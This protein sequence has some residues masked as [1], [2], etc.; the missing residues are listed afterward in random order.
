[1]ARSEVLR[2][3]V[4]GAARIAPAAIIRPA[5]AVDGV[6]VVA[7]AAR[8][9]DRARSFAARHGIGKVHESY[10]SLLADDDVDAVYN[11][12]PNG[13]HG[14]WTIA[15][16]E[17]GKHVLCEKPFTANA[18]EAEDVAAVARRTDRTVMEA[19][20]YRYHPLA[21]RLVSLVR[22]GELGELRRIE[23]WF[24]SPLVRGSD[25]R[26]QRALAGGSTMDLGC[27]TIHLVRAL[28]GSEPEVV[29][30]SARE[31]GAGVDRW[32]DAEVRIGDGATGRITCGM[33]TGR[34]L[35][36]GARITLEHGTIRVTNPYAPHYFHRVIVTDRGHRRR[37]RFTKKP[38]YEFQLRAFVDAV[39]NDGPVLTGVDD[40]IANMRV[41]DACYRAAG[42]EVRQPTV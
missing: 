12:L 19:F 29:R 6:E 22:S 17:A 41:I 37:E 24:C 28:A 25:I 39:R 4:L 33:L 30:A 7:V 18:D 42:M 1:M 10:A 21:Q 3:G 14:A 34:V 5:R 40:A 11:P 35:A 9:R 38:T 27:Y 13:L 15:A 2:I 8:D 26:W 31:R 32:M 20:H 23:A 16:L 36:L